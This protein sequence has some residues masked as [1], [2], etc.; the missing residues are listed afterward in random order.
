MRNKAISVA[1]LM[2]IMASWAIAEWTPYSSINCPLETDYISSLNVSPDGKLFIGTHGFGLAIKDN[3]IWN[4]FNSGT[5][6]VPINYANCSKFDQDTLF[7]GSAS[8]NLDMQPLGE[9]LSILNPTDSTWSGMNSGLE[10]NPI[11]T[12]IEITPEYR[13][14]ST[15]GGGI[16][17]FNDVGWIRYQT[18]F[19]TEYSYANSQQ[20]TFQV[21]SGTYLYT[22]YIKG[23]DYDPVNDILWI[24]TLNGGAVAY[25]GT[26]W[27][28]YT[29]NN[30][31]LPSNRVQVV[32]VNPNSGSVFFGTFGFG[33]AEKSGDN[34]TVYNTGNSPI[35][36]NYIYSLEIRPDN[37]DLW[38][39]TNYAINVLTSSSEW[40]AFIPPDSGLVWGQYYSDI[41]FDSSANVWVA[42]YGGGIASKELTIDNSELEYELLYVDVK[43][44]K[45]FLREPR[46]NNILWVR[47]H[48]EPAVELDA[49]DTI[50]INVS[51]DMG[52]VYSWQSSFE[53]FSHIFNG[54]NNDI[55]LA[56]D[57]DA[58][59]SLR[60]QNNR[61]RI[62]LYHIDIN[63]ALNVD[64]LPNPG[65]LDVRFQLG[66]YAGIQTVYIGESDPVADV[67]TDTLDYAPGDILLSSGY[68]P[69][70]V[71]IDDIQSDV[72]LSISIP[73]N[74]PNPFNAQT[75]IQFSM[76]ISASARLTVYDVLGRAI[77][78]E[79]G[80]YI[81][82]KHSIHW[83]GTDKPS[84]MYY[85][86]I[87]YGDQILTGRM[88]LLK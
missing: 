1:I 21:T 68:Y 58:S 37:G 17:I 81:A 39:G 50:S 10:I 51:S 9:G 77:T 74:Y 34:W 44:L 43:N 80:Y 11:I 23:L 28:K 88:T 25:N 79:E 42:T 75:V 15:Y 67:D 36:A 40:Q 7:V 83:D 70:I 29:V 82:G 61:D 35:L 48:L 60:Y 22:D 46:R 8:G 59:M 3:T 13:A 62:K 38:I 16:T 55:Y 63:P 41:A 71:G 86:V 85:Y 26:D 5:S 76:D 57:G 53:N 19:R 54:R 20:Q 45:V 84:G 2:F 18:N 27:I 49:D 78:S 33:L 66:N 47:A 4:I 73:S 72:P 64:N 6:G 14:V 52:E 56:V 32:K 12:G 31:G 65:A 87:R 30:S 69:Q 24:A